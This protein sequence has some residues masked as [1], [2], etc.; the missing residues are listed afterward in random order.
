MEANLAQK[1]ISFALCCKWKEAIKSN[2][3]ILKT[4]PEDVEALNRLA[5]AYFENGE[6]KKAILI[7]KSVLKIDPINN[8]ALN[9]LDRFKQKK[10][11][12]DQI[13]KTSF[14]EEPGKTRITTLINLGSESVYSC[15]SAGDEIC[16]VTHA[17]KVSATTR[18]GKYV[19]KLTDDLSARMRILIKSGK[20]FQVYIKST[21]KNIVKVFIKG[22]SISFPIG[23]SESLSEF[24]S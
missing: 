17:H 3:E 15:L 6:V 4:D 11:S 16:L 8:I 10:T 22:E 7:S 9:S 5:K 21:N 13:R 12:S 14:I 20:K 23:G 19:G 18:D 2:L 1:S 24:S